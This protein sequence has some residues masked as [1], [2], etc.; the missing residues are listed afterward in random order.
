MAHVKWS[1]DPTHSEVQFK[2]KHLM[3]TTVTGYFQNFS[4]EAETE[5]EQFT[6]AS[7]VVF[8]ADVNSISTN[9]EQRD[10]H[11]KS[12]DFFD[13][14]QHNEVRFVGTN[15]ENVGGDEYK[16]HGDLT[17]KGTTKP[18]T[19]NVDF[20]GIVVDPYGQTKAG[21]TVTGKISRKE[22]GLTWNAVTEAGSVVVSDEIKLQAEIQ[23]VKQA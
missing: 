15:Y 16:L 7:S 14:A 10:T 13:A 18:I 11:L 12:P 6:N 5:D 2:V 17:I 1:L 21:F 8:T 20:G 4:V 23:L 9:N 19:V 3:I 22:F